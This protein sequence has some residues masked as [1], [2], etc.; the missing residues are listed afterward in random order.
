[1]LLEYPN[2]KLELSNNLSENMA[3]SAVQ[4]DYI[5]II[6]NFEQKNEISRPSSVA[7]VLQVKPPTVISMFRQLERLQLISYDKKSGALLTTKGRHRAEKLVRKHRLLETFLDRVL[8]VEDPILHD[9][10]EKLEH[11]ISD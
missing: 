5:K 6:W 8:E 7:E 2:I 9:E 10:A 4:E 1:M 3:L 11:V